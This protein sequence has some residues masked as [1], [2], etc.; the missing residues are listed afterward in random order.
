MS[1]GEGRQRRI[2]FELFQDSSEAVV[3][4]LKAADG[5]LFP[6]GKWATIHAIQGRIDN[7]AGL[8]DFVAV[9]FIPGGQEDGS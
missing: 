1:E 2:H 3:E 8:P 9:G 6:R 4:I 5:E 7:V